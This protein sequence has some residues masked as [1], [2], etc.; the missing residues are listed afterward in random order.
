M[1]SKLL[2]EI[3]AGYGEWAQKKVSKTLEDVHR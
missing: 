2:R 1:F 3:E